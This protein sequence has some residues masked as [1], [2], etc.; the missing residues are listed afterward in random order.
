MAALADESGYAV[1]TQAGAPLLD[2][3]GLPG[4]TDPA[5]LAARTGLP[6][7]A[8]TPNYASQVAQFL[9]AHAVTPAYQ[10]SRII[11][12]GGFANY[13]GID[14]ID[15]GTSDV[16]QP[17]TMPGGATAIGRVTL[18]LSPAGGGADV[19]VSL[20]ADSS[21]A[22]GA[23]IAST[24]VPASWLAQLA[25]P[26]GLAS[27]GPLATAQGNTMMFGAGASTPWAQP[28]VSL[29][30]AGNYAAP[31]S[32]GNYTILLSGYDATAGAGVAT[33]LTIGYLGG[34]AVSG[35]VPQPSVPQAAWLAMAAATSDTVV[36]AGGTTSSSHFANAWTASWD[37]STGTVG[38][39]TAQAS[40]P[41][42]VVSGGMAAYGSTA[43]V[44]GGNTANTDATAVA[45]VYHASA[46]N[47][48]IQSWTAGPSLPQPLTNPYV[49]AVN[50]WLI[51]AGGMN[52][53]GTVQTAVW[54]SLIKPD[55][56][57]AGW[58]P[59]PPLPTAAYAFSP[60]WNLAV[61]DT[62]MVI[63]S[64]ATTGGNSSY[65]QALT[66]TADGP[67]PA[68]QSMD[69]YV[70]GVFQTAFYPGSAAGQWQVFNLHLTSYDVIPLVPMPA[71][72]VPLPAS[73]LASGGTYHILVHQDGGDLNDYASVALDPSALPTAAQTRPNGGGSW[74][75]L[76]GGLAVIA[77]VW[78]Q[79]PGG[80]V[81]H[82]WEDSGARITSMVYGSADGQLLGL[83]EA[84][85][86]GDG[87]MLATVTGIAYDAFGQPASL[88]QLA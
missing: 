23:V 86:F 14:W 56:S 13:G 49:A 5:W 60:G 31:V 71:V 1:L 64:G 10:G 43:Y 27:A 6:G 63:V 62:A 87:T 9:T 57:L 54:Y 36:F 80:Q 45:S 67:A 28:A 11:A 7:D 18:P 72:S 44:A 42:A 61:T 34:G 53:S 55:G 19:T 50:G 66:V 33:A 41:A 81:L 8:A 15:L 40:L 32:S 84:T 30:G 83:L 24:R 37:P 68:W 74:T 29:N 35:P 78:D 65:T 77:G 48:Q 51:V 79:S 38:A 76:P 73:G 59:G 58:Q 46:V 4:T 39:W 22:P 16:D 82:T 21:G 26:S 2:E 12:P 47:G 75:G 70:A 20:C 52:S 17:F 88:A 69:V 3:S 25:A 85:V